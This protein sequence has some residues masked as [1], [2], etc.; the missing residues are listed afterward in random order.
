MTLWRSKALFE[1]AQRGLR[2][3][4]QLLSRGV[5]DGQSCCQAVSHGQQALGKS[6]YRKLSRFG[7]FLFGT[8]A[9]VF[10][11]GFGTQKLVSQVCVFGLNHG[12]FGQGF[13]QWVCRC[14]WTGTGLISVHGGLVLTRRL[15]RRGLMRF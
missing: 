1:L 6:L 14:L 2:A 3:F 4:A 7:N 5:G 9:G 13:A 8:S 12:Q 10:Y 11:L 15:G